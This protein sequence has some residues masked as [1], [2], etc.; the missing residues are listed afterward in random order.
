MSSQLLD[1]KVTNGKAWYALHVKP[2]KEM[3]VY[4]Y[5]Y[6]SGHDLDV[7]YPSFIIDPVNPRSSRIR[8]Y[9]PRYLFVEA[10]LDQL[11]EKFL[12]WIPGSVGLVCF[13]GEPAVVPEHFMQDLKK[14]VIAFEKAGGPPGDDIRAGDRIRVA[15]GPFTDYEGVFHTRLSGEERVQVFLDWLGRRVTVTMKAHDIRKVQ[16]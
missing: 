6:S 11:G 15:S 2:H 10:A 12:Q 4:R 5:L 8:P 9:F 14:R 13:G 1:D 7:Y 3:Q 16:H